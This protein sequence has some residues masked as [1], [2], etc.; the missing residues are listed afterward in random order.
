MLSLENDQPFVRVGVI[1]GRSIGNAV[2]R[3]RAKRLIRH[4]VQPFLPQIRAGWDILFIA[5][6]NLA[7]SAY[8]KAVE[9]I[10][11]LL[12]RSGILI[13]KNDIDVR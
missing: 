9:A 12:D 11:S 1:A 4:A 3:N 5:R 13:D 6:A 10:S 8:Q 2:Q 7:G